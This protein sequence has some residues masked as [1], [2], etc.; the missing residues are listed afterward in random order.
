[1]YDIYDYT[2]DGTNPAPVDKWFPLLMGWPTKVFRISPVS[3]G[4]NDELTPGFFVAGR[5]R[6]AAAP[7]AHGLCCLP[8]KQRQRTSAGGAY[9][10]H[11]GENDGS[12][13]NFNGEINHNRF[14]VDHTWCNL[15]QFTQ[16]E[17]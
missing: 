10:R 7:E 13:K 1:M 6:Q 15:M 17:I 5:S 12:K 14:V 9:E 16:G 11:G 4:R 3:T 8:G 2:V